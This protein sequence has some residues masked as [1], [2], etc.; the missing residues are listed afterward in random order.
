MKYK[1]SMIILMAITVFLFAVAGACAGSADDAALTGKDAM[2]IESIQDINLNA[3]EMPADSPKT[4]AQLACDINESQNTFEVKDD[5]AF[6]NQADSGPVIIDK[7]DFTINGNNHVLDGRGQSGIF[8]ITS[9]NV[10]ISNLV[11][12]NGNAF[13]GGAIYASGQV[14]L[15]NVT[16]IAN[17]ASRGGAIY[18]N[19]Q[20]ALNNASFICNNASYGGAIAYYNNILNCTNSRFIANNASLGGA[21]Y[22]DGQLILDNATFINNNA[23]AGGAIFYMSKILNCSNSRFACNNASQGGAIYCDGQFILDNATFINNNAGYGGAI[24][25][26]NKIWNCSNSRFIDN[27]AE[28]GQSIYST[29]AILNVCNSFVTSN[30]HGEFGQ[31]YALSS[32]VNI[33]NSQFINMTSDYASALYFRNSESSIINSSFVNLTAEKSAGAIAIRDS[34]NLYI[35]CSEF[36]NTKSFKNA[37]AIM[38]DYGEE[39]YNATIIDCVFKNSSSMIGGAYIQLG[40]NL[41]FNNTCFADNKASCDGGAVYISCEYG[42]FYN[43]NFTSNAAGHL[44]DYHAHGGAIYSDLSVLKVCNSSFINNSAYSGNAIYASDSGYDISHS[45]FLNNTAAIFTEFDLESCSL[46]NNIYNNDTVITNGSHSYATYVYSPALD[47]KLVNNTINVANLPSRFDLRDWGLVT[48]VKEQGD[49]G[50]CWTFGMISA[51]ESALLKAYGLEFDLSESNMQHNMLKYFPYGDKRLFEG[52]LFMTAASYLVGWYGPALEETDSYDEVGKLSPFLSEGYDVIHIQDV[53]IVR[54]DDVPAGSGI[55]SAILNYGALAVSYYGVQNAAGGYYNPE[56][57]AQY[58]NESL[59][60]THSVSLIGWDDYFSKDNFLITPPGDGAWI[61]KSNWGTEWGD[62]G[63][64]YISYYD[65]TFIPGCFMDDNAVGIV[66]ENTVPYNKNYQHDFIWS[67]NFAGFNDDNE[68]SWIIDEGDVNRS[69]AY[70]NQFESAGDDLIAAVGT[71]FNEAGVNYTVEIYVNDELK[72]IQE[73]LSP[74]CGYHTITLNEYI[75][76]KKGDIFKAVITSNMIPFCYCPWSRVHYTENASFYYDGHEWKDL[77][78]SEDIIACL[79]VYTVEDADHIINYTFK[80]LNN[81]ISWSEDVLELMHD[82]TFDNKSDDGPVIIDK[83]DFTIN[84]NNHVLD[85]SGQSAIFNITGNNVTISNLIFVNGNAC[86]GGAIYAEGQLTLNNVTFIANNADFGGAIYAEGQ[87]ILDNAT[88]IDNNAGYGGAVAD[89]GEIFTCMNSRFTGNNAGY[90]GAVVHDMGIFSCMNSRFID[91]NGELGSSIYSSNGILNVCNSSLTSNMSGK[92]GQIFGIGSTVN[93]DNSEF[94]NISSDYA[95]AL[96]LMDCES[97]I[98]NSRFVN[99]TGDKSAGAIAIRDS[100]NSYIKGCEF[101]NTKSFKNAGA[102][103]VDYRM[104]SYNATIIDCAFRNASSMIGGAY[105]QLGG[106]LVLRSSNFT[107]NNAH[108]GGAV[109]TSYANSTIDDCIFDS[110]ELSG[111]DSTSYGGAIVCDMGNMTLVGSRFINNSAYLG[112]AVYACDSWY[113]VTNC[114]F[115]NNGNAI[116]SDFDRNGCSLYANE[117]NNDSIIPNQTFYAPTSFAYPGLNLTLINNTINVTALPSR[118]DLRDWGWITPVKYQGLM[119]ACWAFAFGD[120]LETALLKATGIRYDIS[121]NYMKNLQIRYSEF[122]YSRTDEA[123]NFF[124][125]LANVLGWLDV[126]EE[127]DEYDEVGKLSVFVDSANKIRLQDAYLIM[128]DK[129]DYVDE[130]KWAILNY[131]AVSISYV[132]SDGE[133]YFNVDTSAQYANESLPPDH[134]SAIIGWDDNYSVDNF[135]IAPP[136]NGAWIVKNSWGTEWGD[137]GYFYL[138]YYDKS[139]VSIG[140]N[141]SNTNTLVACIFTNAIDYHANYQ[142]DL[143]GFIGFDDDYTQYSNEFSAEYDDLIAGVGTYFNQSGIDYSFDIY[144]N[145]NPVY[146]QSGISEFAGYRTIVLDSYVPVKVNDTFKVVFKSNA[147]PCEAYSRNHYIHGMSFASADGSTWSDITLENM[148]VC[149]KVYTVADDSK[150][151]CNN[152]IS[153]DYDGGKY[154]TVNV[155]TA[156]GRAVVGAEVTFKINGRTTTVPTD[157]DGVAKIRITDVP[158]KYV[159]TTSYNNKTYKNTVTV[160]QVLTAFKVTVKKTAKKFTLKAKLK[161]NGKLVKGKTVTFKFNGKTYK[162]KTNAKGIAQKILKKNVIKKLKKG[163]TYTVKVTYIKDTV[164]TT[165]KVK[166]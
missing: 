163:K 150:I 63:I 130:V 108:V 111:N 52:G 135:L 91:N 100:G 32:T 29:N 28:F 73:G 131:G 26:R 132:S 138:S 98:I 57:A 18:S 33:D 10:T 78:V 166:K 82:Y 58:T 159:V 139:L 24:F 129:I 125:A 92:Y 25:Y 155:V 96:Y 110:N 6:A 64:F 67:G 94:I 39:A 72:L 119:G 65:K 101:A 144:V 133:P 89:Y 86:L 123:G 2:P 81:H 152:D 50:A 83:S 151:I 62:E 137:E 142:T 80:D 38:V 112:N 154:F 126:A 136:A 118:F 165:V 95:P 109:Y 42:E 84:G 30:R 75:P 20:M 34:G 19:G 104:G 46:E 13:R 143:N 55:K 149:L 27:S 12:V 105:I 156:D 87:L 53:V 69:I 22:C 122:G 140:G 124:R 161:I 114:L 160:K 44:S 51:V 43:C 88:F 90:G 97:S 7:S 127:E 107:G 8:N 158:K 15:N 148:T 5:Y 141:S 23:T 113:N 162:V 21:I 1:R 103:L 93:M 56:T 157:S 85:G 116:F 16:F 76:V 41:L 36:I 4:F 147:L 145:A 120:A 128:T 47:L 121:E 115:E 66:I 71:Y 99:L 48:P 35:R 74:F 146:S 117:Y 11:F 153:V 134:A 60:A 54:N 49:M 106:N 14:T 61:V 45:T 40:G 79:K 164:K 37:G 59:G 102:I 31:I 17:N 70:A 3:D 9:D 68:L 77:F